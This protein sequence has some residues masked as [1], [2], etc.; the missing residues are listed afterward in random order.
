[1]S[2]RKTIDPRYYSV[3]PEWVW[4]EKNKDLIKIVKLEVHLKYLDERNLQDAF[5]FWLK[6][7]PAIETKNTEYAIGGCGLKIISQSNTAIK[8]ILFSSGQDVLES[9]DYVVESLYQTFIMNDSNI[10][11]SWKELPIQ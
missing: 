5:D 6:Q 1:M 3:R 7:F 2:N 10:V 9:L 8:I 4:S 11:V